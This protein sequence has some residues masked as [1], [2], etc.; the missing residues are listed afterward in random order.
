[1][2]NIIEATVALMGT[3]AFWMYIG[4]MAVM[5]LGAYAELKHQR[6]RTNRKYRKIKE[7]LR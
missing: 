1:M 7:G 2:M 3:P 4:V 5:G 6:R